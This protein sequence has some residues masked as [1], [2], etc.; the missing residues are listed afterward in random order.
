[1]R[2]ELL[3]D[4]KKK[5]KKKKFGKIIYLFCWVVRAYLKKKTRF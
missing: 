5:K 1:M 4:K 2:N 3:K